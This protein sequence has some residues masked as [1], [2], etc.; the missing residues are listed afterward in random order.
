VRRAGVRLRTCSLDIT[1]L[2]AFTGRTPDVRERAAG[3]GV[4]LPQMGHMVRTG[5]G[6]ALSVR[7]ERW[8]LLST[9]AAPGTRQGQWQER[10]GDGAAVLD[11]SCALKAFLV[12]G[13]AA[14]TMLARGCRIDL[15]TASFPSGLAAASVMAQVQ[16]IFASLGTRLLLLSPVTTAQHLQEWLANTSRPFGFVTPGDAT[17][18]LFGGERIA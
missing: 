9:Q 7:P 1:E 18:D 14:R 12:D 10:C 16:V 6:F 15:E 17:L 4:Q 2:A 11:H 3:H 13:P 8:L 5:S